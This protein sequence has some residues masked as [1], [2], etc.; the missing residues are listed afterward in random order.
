MIHL[1]WFSHYSMQQALAKPKEILEKAKQLSQ[2]AIAITDLN[3]W[4][5]LL[6]FYEKAQ[7]IWVK[8]ILWAHMLFS[9]DWKNFMSL[10]LLAKNFQWYKNLIKLISLA[11]TKNFKTTPYL[12]I[13]DLNKYWKNLIWITWWDWEIEK[14]I[15]ANENDKLI[16]EKIN[17]YENIFDG[18]FYLEFLTLSYEDFPERK[19]IEN[20]FKEFIKLWKKAIV[21]SFY[22]YINKEDKSTYDVLLCIKNNYQ[23][24]SPT[25]PKVKWDYYIMSEEQVKEVLTKNNISANLQEELINQTHTIADKINI[26]VPLHQV[27]FPMYTVPEKYKKFYEKLKDED[28]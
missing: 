16:L 22:K 27:L 24:Y 14:L 13:E 7:N 9:Y 5:W 11:N 25:R 28:K 3:N 17:E 8:P 10:V 20:K 18:D 12:T 26:E 23:Y 1:H 6:E 21:S 4:Y 19:K 15:L 2:D